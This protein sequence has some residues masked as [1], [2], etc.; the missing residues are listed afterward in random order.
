M[1]VLYFSTQ[2][3]KSIPSVDVL[4]Y[5]ALRGRET[6]QLEQTRDSARVYQLTPW[7]LTRLQGP[8]DFFFNSFSFHE[9]ECDVCRNYAAEVV[10]V[11]KGGVMLHSSIGGHKTG[12]GGQRAPVTLAF[13][14]SLFSDSFAHVAQIDGFWPRLYGGD[15]RMTR[16]MAR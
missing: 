9:M 2:F 4:D 14:Q 16:L 3:L 7:Q 5:R 10:R 11:T 6:I 13:L 1:P 15:P 12:A 8:I